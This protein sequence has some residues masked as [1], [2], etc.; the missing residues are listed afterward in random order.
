MLFPHRKTCMLLYENKTKGP[1]ERVKKLF[2]VARYLMVS[3]APTLLKE[4]ES[5]F[6]L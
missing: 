6:S 5:W 2:P 1:G 4:E 3:Y